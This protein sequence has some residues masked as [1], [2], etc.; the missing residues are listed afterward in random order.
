MTMAPQQQV[1]NEEFLEQLTRL[2]ESSS[3]AHSVFVSHK[4]ISKDA[5]LAEP[6]IVV[7]ATDGRGGS[8]ASSNRTKFTTHIQ[9]SKLNAF[10]DQY[11]AILRASTAAFLRKRDKAKERRVD[12]LLKEKRKRME[13]VLHSLPVTST[14]TTANNAKSK[15]VET[16]GDGKATN[17][18]GTAGGVKKTTPNVLKVTS[19]GAKRGAGRRK[20]Q[21][22]QHK[23]KQ[24]RR[25]QKRIAATTTAAQAS[26]QKVG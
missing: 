11:S 26:T 4:K 14:T 20:R 15:Q 2:F 21:Q 16:N 18:A 5:S 3:K 9:A 24:L 17:A 25:E 6:T 10:Q 22:A 1:T 19:I 8:S 12:K 7:R 23:A 13:E